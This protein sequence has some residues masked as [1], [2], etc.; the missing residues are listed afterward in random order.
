MT[1]PDRNE[2]SGHPAMA[3]TL[4]MIGVVVVLILIA[5]ATVMA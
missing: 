2:Q 4:L 3:A 5:V 1:E